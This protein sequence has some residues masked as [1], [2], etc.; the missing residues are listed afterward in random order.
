LI[1]LKEPYGCVSTKNE[2]FDQVKAA[3]GQTFDLE[4]CS[5]NDALDIANEKFGSLHDW[6]N[7]KCRTKIVSL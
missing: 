6:F 7:G 5:L 1:K 3:A 2:F 4:D